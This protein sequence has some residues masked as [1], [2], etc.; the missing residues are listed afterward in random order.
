MNETW[1]QMVGHPKYIVSDVGEIANKETMKVYR[2]Q[3]GPTGY[4]QVGLCDHGKQF[5][6]KV[7]REVAKAF[8]QND[9]NK[10]FVNHIDGNKLN[11]KV[12][13]LEWCTPKENAIHAA[14]VLGVK[15]A[16]QRMV[17]CVET[18][19][20]YKSAA[21]AAREV[22]G[23]ARK[24]IRCCAGQRKHHRGFSWQYVT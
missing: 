1:K 20:I 3:L 14:I 17:L 8:I 22:E 24:I 19:R 9:E 7:H 21:E 2:K 11:N 12:E 4:W 18:Q 15:P 5:V 10:P 6:V 16:N 23:C 13:N